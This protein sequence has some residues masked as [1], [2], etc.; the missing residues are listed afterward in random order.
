MQHLELD[1]L[2]KVRAIDQ[3]LQTAPCRFQLLELRLVQNLIDLPAQGMVDLGDHLVDPVLVDRLLVVTALQDLADERG[4]A[5]AGHGITFLCRA[6]HGVG[7]QLVEQRGLLI[8][9]QNLGDCAFLGHGCFSV[10]NWNAG[11]GSKG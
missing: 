3:Q 7:Q 11:Q 5:L 4:H 1:V 2:A 10:F 8:G 9:R 6:D